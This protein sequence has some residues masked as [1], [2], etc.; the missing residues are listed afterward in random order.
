MIPFYWSIVYDFS[1]GYG[2]GLLKFEW[3]D[4]VVDSLFKLQI[5]LVNG[6]LGF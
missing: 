1:Y 4:A 5:I 3:I 6:I 2:G